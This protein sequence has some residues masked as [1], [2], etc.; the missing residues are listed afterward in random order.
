VDPDATRAWVSHPSLPPGAMDPP[1][2][3]GPVEGAPQ[4]GADPVSRDVKDFPG[5]APADTGTD[6]S[7]QPDDDTAFRDD[8]LQYDADYDDAS[9]DEYGQDAQPDTP[10]AVAVPAPD[11]VRRPWL[12]PAAALAVLALVGALA[13]FL[14]QSRKPEPLATYNASSQQSVVAFSVHYPRSWR[15]MPV[16]NA[17]IIAKAP[18][19]V[20]VF[21]GPGGWAA[22]RDVVKSSP[23]QAVG[24]YFTS[25]GAQLNPTQDLQV[26]VRSTLDNNSSVTAL[27]SPTQITIGG[28]RGYELEGTLADAS[29]PDVTL[30]AVFD[31]VALPQGT[32]LITFFAPPSRFEDQRHLFTEMRGSVR[33][34]G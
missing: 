23:D 24:M 26:W 3:S 14:L 22:A 8:D 4:V 30:H 16:S 28:R 33:F 6:D 21:T 19:T 11:R 32:A 5:G 27:A 34:P 29:S 31:V 15:T 10:H 25:L 7:Y 13:L 20:D 9:L 17:V 12:L 18:Q 1:R 2:W